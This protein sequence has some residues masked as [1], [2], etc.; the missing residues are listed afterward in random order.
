ML[1]FSQDIIKTFKYKDKLSVGTANLRFRT[2]QKIIQATAAQYSGVLPS[3]HVY[4]LSK[5]SRRES[6]PCWRCWYCDFILRVTT[7]CDCLFVIAATMSQLR[8]SKFIFSSHFITTIW[9]SLRCKG[10]FI[11]LYSLPSHPP[12][13]SNPLLNSPP[14][15]PSTLQLSICI[16][17]NINPLHVHKIVPT[18]YCLDIVH[19]VSQP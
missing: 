2:Q 9:S 15:T 14:L 12:P 1:L 18:N 7:S 16:R 3:E 6:R 8:D 4:C 19:H 5:M 10:V 13:L 17:I 11:N